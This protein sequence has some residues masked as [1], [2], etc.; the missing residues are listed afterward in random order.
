MIFNNKKGKSSLTLAEATEK[1]AQL[2]LPIALSFT[3]TNLEEEKRKF[4]ESDTYN[5]QFKYEITQNKNSEI[6][7]ELAS[8]TEISGVDP[9]IS[10][11]YIK[12]I[13]AKAQASDLMHAAGD[14]DRVT[15]ISLKRFGQP[16]AILFRNASRVL[17]GLVKNYN[18]SSEMKGAEQLE[19]DQIK[20]AFSTVFEEIG[21]SEWSADV[22]K[23]IADDS[24]KIA[25]KRKQVLMDPGISRSRAY[26]RKTIVHEVGT[27]VLRAYNGERSGV[28]ALGKANLPSYLDIE[29]GLATYNEEKMGL[30]SESVLKNKAVHV[31]STYVGQ[32]MSFRE[33]HSALQGILSKNLAFDNTYRVKRGLGD[34][35]KPGIYSKDIVYFRGYRRVKKKLAADGSLFDKLYAGKIDLNRV[36]WVDEGLIPKP[37]LVFDPAVFK[38][39]F[40]KAGI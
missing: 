24:V 40:K 5:P 8:V 28:P 23:K 11:F 36:S 10:E 33:L 20:E 22:S 27:H 26:L 25:I 21:L 7:K 35:S 4:N 39:A 16:S 12:L 38:A 29:E 9:R 18:L 2:R 13:S 3:P 14:N 37:K 32:N 1:L 30:L 17:R 6:L 15:E 31:W 34:T 19:Y